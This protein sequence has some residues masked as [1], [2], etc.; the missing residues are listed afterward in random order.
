MCAL[1]LKIAPNCLPMGGQHG[2]DNTGHIVRSS[3][4]DGSLFRPACLPIMPLGHSLQTASVRSA[5]TINMAATE[6]H[7][8][9]PNYP[10]NTRRH[11]R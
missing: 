3:A 1:W 2:R 7:L 4:G 10:R 5:G 11:D 6:L 9:S 8:I